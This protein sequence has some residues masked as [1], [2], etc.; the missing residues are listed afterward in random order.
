MRDGCGEHFRDEGKNVLFLFDSITRFAEAH[1]GGLLAG[2]TP[3]PQR[4]P[5]P[6]A[7][8]G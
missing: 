2:E 5:T 7:L 3:C 8:C 1:R 4:L 6:S